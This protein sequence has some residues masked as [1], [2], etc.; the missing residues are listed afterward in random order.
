[1]DDKLKWYIR[2]SIANWIGNQYLKKLG[3]EE[4][5]E[6]IKEITTIADEDADSMGCMIPKTDCGDMFCNIE[7]ENCEICPDDCSCLVG[8]ICEPDNPFAD[9]IGCA[10][11]IECGNG[12]IEET[13]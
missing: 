11:E 5:L 10:P 9:P 12:M 3:Q 6:N 8:M 2:Q 4:Y 1:M 7:N 13:E